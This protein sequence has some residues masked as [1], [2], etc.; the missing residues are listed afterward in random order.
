[1]LHYIVRHTLFLILILV[2][3]LLGYTQERCGTML[4]WNIERQNMPTLE[5]QK[6]SLDKAIKK[7]K[8]HSTTPNSY[9][10]PVVFHIIS[11]NDN[12]TISTEQV[13]SQ[14]SVLNEDFT[15]TNSDANQTPYEFSTIAADCNIS[16][17]LAQ[18]T[19]TNDTTSGITYTTTPISSFSLYDNRIF[20]DSLGGKNIWDSEKYLNIY[21]CDLNNA[22]GFSSFP[23]GNSSRDAV[24]IDYQNFGTL[25]IAPPFNKGRTATHEVGHW[26]NL[27]HIWGDGNCGSDQVDDT[28]TQELENYGCPTHPS[29][30]CN[31]S[32]D[33]FQNFMDYTN[34]ACM[35]LFTEGQKE[36]MQ[37]TINLQRTQLIN[38][39]NCTLPFEDIGINDNISPF[40]NQSYC[41]N[42]MNLITS[43]FNYSDKIISSATIYFQIDNNNEQSYFWSG[44][45]Q[46]NAS[47]EIDLGTFQLNSGQH[48][49]KIYSSLPN[50][51]RDLDSTNDTLDLNFLIQEGTLFNIEIQTDNYAEEN[52]W[53]ILNQDDQV[54][55]FENN[56]I[57]NQINN[58][59]FCQPLDSCYQ[60]VIYDDYNDGI[61][62]DYGNGYLSVNGQYFSGNFNTQSQ[63]D[64]CTVSSIQEN[65]SENYI[66]LF[67]NPINNILYIESSN[68]IQQI[69]IYDFIGKL[70]YQKNCSINKEAVNLYHFKSGT[71]IISIKT[72]KTRN[73]RKLNKL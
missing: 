40:P 30:S 59:Q 50:G 26:L 71:Y 67:P 36:R 15:R 60:F 18:R 68:I 62:C 29:P 16:F 63:I 28:P 55:S 24:V 69:Q 33:M 54:I 12:F 21:V 66:N 1:M 41:G 17:C 23:G 2:L 58:F 3:P 32:G 19:P 70:V 9:T 38:N 11:N 34:D 49:L 57:S 64:L 44:T 53:E 73:I 6:N 45:L 10:I 27:L 72:S 42:E 35:N 47:V 48:T 37:A 25:N 5:I 43:L 61:C 56:L 22:L 39:L 65:N 4:R 14:L 46:P 51:Y 7:W 31:N 8:K 20:Y 13:M 52:H